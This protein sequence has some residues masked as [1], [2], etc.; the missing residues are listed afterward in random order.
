MYLFIGRLTAN[1]QRFL[2]ISLVLNVSI[3][4]A[5]AHKYAANVVMA[6]QSVKVGETM[7]HQLL[8]K[9]GDMVWDNCGDSGCNYEREFN[10]EMHGSGCPKKGTGIIKVE[11]NYKNLAMRNLLLEHLDKT[12][13]EVQGETKLREANWRLTRFGPGGPATRECY[14]MDRDR[15]EWEMPSELQVTLW[16]ETQNSGQVKYSVRTGSS[17]IGC[18]NIFTQVS[19]ITLMS[20]HPIAAILGNAIVLVCSTI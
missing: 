15:V 13:K 2:F 4:S 10:Y 18:P 1:I 8:F 12:I 16:H 5:V 17:R 19:S 14:F 20:T 9:P 3:Q 6:G 11:A 7:P